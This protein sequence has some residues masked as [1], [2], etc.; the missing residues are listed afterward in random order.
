MSTQQTQPCGSRTYPQESWSPFRQASLAQVS[1]QSALAGQLSSVVRGV[2]S[3]GLRIYDQV[4]FSLQ[5][6]ALSMIAG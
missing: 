5:M 2:N 6:R 4:G 1:P 3:S